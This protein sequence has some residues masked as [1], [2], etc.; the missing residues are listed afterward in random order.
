MPDVILGMGEVGETFF[1]L[2]RER[3][4][5]CIGID[6]EPSKCKNYSQNNDL[7]ATNAEY[8][9][10]CIPGGLV[11]FNS[12]VLNW[13][14]KYGDSLKAVFLHST[15]RPG[16]AAKIQEQCN[17]PVISTPTRGVHRRFLSDMKLYTKFVAVD[18]SL[19]DNI[20]VDIESRF[21]KVSWMSNTK[22]TE[23]AK[24][25]TDTSYYGWLINYA[26]ITKMIADKENV[27]YDEM[28][29]FADEIQK[30]LGNRPKLYPGII[31]G[32]C[33][34]PNL[35]LVEYDDLD[36]IRKINEMYMTFGNNNA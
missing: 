1:E 5:G 18:C 28:W 6:V 8:L 19:P 9:H 3:G 10:V 16:T 4:Y 12:I 11:A 7:S 15:V 30:Y 20:K 34:I 35:D 13:I 23:L 17:V 26:Q 29:T 32:H 33:V 21:R 36:A 2:L 25:L 31:G 24:I 27:D 14:S 22:T